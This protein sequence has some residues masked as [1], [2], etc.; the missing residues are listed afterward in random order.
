MGGF[1]VC[2]L[3]GKRDAHKV[4]PLRQKLLPYGLQRTK[5]GTDG[6]LSLAES[7]QYPAGDIF[8]F[9]EFHR[10]EHF[11]SRD[12]AYHLFRIRLLQRRGRTLGL[13][14]GRRNIL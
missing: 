3:A 4:E 5:H 8:T 13:D 6:L 12:G 14:L 7:R 11:N 1:V 9:G 2:V 10:T